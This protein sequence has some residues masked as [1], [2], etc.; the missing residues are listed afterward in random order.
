MALHGSIRRF[1]GTEEHWVSYTERLEQYFAAN[2][3]TVAEKKRAVLLSS[4]G[5]ATYKLIRS[6]TA[7]GD[8]L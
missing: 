5:P 2:A 4:C 6:L 8:W 1:D 7:I 3:A